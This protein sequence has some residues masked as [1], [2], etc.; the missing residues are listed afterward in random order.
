MMAETVYILCALTS[1]LCAGLLFRQFR[2]TRASLLFWST[3]CFACLALTNVLLFVD[4]VLLPDID[5]SELRHS[6]TFAGMGMLLYGLIRER[7]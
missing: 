7:F 6:V 1:I 2:S 5:L 3:C 4:L